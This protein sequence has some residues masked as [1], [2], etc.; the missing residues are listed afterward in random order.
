MD[1]IMNIKEIVTK[2]YREIV[3][4]ATQKALFLKTPP[5][6]WLRTNR[7]ALKMPVKIILEKAG[8]KQSELYRIEK[9]EVEG[10]LTLNKLK[11]TAKAMGCE[12]HYAV[13]PRG[14]INHIIEDRAR[15]HAINIL[16][17]VNI[18][19][20]LEDQETTKEQIEL[21]I[22]KLSDELAKDMPGWFWEDIK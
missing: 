4:A 3:D 5:E 12:L 16:R 2:Q 1:V 14:E 8:I 18:H 22:N 21:Q 17:R 6:G 7:K 20:Q 10:K 9:A 19:M 15:R 11:K 13:V